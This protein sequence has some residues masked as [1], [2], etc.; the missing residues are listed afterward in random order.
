MKMFR[1]CLLVCLGAGSMFAADVTGKWECGVKGGDGVVRPLIANLKA[2][3]SKLSGSL[4]GINSPDIE[5]FDGKVEGS[6][7]AWS[8]KRP[9]QGGAV[10][11]N[12]S[13][14]ISGDEIQLKIVRADGQG[15]AM[16][17]TATRSK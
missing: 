3:G 10:Q 15:A 4:N 11:F 7:V 9:I 17:C 16:G 6:Q 8:S 5:I 13:G 1:S 14:T 12:Y 2:D